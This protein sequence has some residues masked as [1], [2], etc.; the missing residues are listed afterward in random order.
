VRRKGEERK[1]KEKTLKV[2][3]SAATQE[4]YVI[5]MGL[6]LMTTFY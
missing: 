5:C 4:Q 2:S 1:I 3:K 6:K